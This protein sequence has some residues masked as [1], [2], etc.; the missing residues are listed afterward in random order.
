MIAREKVVRTTRCDD[1]VG[2]DYSD[3]RATAGRAVF[4]N[5]GSTG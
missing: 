2:G 4:A 1:V 3:V 5:W